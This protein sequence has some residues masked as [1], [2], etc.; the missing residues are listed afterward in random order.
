MTALALL[1][2]AYFIPTFV[3]SARRHSNWSS[4]FVLN[5]FLG[6]TFIGWVVALVWS[7]SAKRIS[8]MP[9]IAQGD[10]IRDKE[11]SVGWKRGLLALG[12]GF[13]ILFIASRFIHSDTITS[14][15]YGSP[16]PVPVSTPILVA[17]IPIDTPSPAA[18]PTPNTTPYVNQLALK[19]GHYIET[20]TPTPKPQRKNAKAFRSPL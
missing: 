11:N 10:A 18:T 8:D 1:T 15:T 5:I 16:I 7:V 17:A 2:L 4:I 13:A 20:A 19:D 14:E 9:A 3:A 6:W 12:I